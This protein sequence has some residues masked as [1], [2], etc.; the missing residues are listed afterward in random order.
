MDRARGSSS[1]Q[2]L[3]QA[4][5]RL[6]VVYYYCCYFI[7]III[8]TITIITIFRVYIHVRERPVG[9]AYVAG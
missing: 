2:G 8:I 7:V 1:L 6:L 3:D 5:H 4:N 9:R